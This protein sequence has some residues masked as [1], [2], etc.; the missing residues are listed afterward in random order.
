MFSQAVSTQRRGRWVEYLETRFGTFEEN[1][2]GVVNQLRTEIELEG[3]DA[4]IDHLRFC[5]AVP[6]QY[7]R[8]SSQEKLYS[9][10]TDVVV[11][12]ALFAIG[13][14]SVVVDEWADSADVQARGE[15]FSLVADAKAFRLSRTAK[16]QKDFKIQALDGWRRNLDYAVL[17][18]PIY[19]LPTR[20]SQIYQQA[21]ARN[22]CIISY[23]HLSTLIAFSV[24]QDKKQAELGFHNILQ[25]ISTL[26][27]S[28][29][30]VD[31]WTG[32][33]KSL[34]GVVKVI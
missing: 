21:I 10:Y 13:L 5:G 4:L 22:V 32:I 34:G 11:S 29:I 6:E 23:S 9:K 28:K 33:N 20:N 19:Q 15:D 24:R 8:D 27:P 2:G 16:N 14:K 7:S 3:V 30:A 18:C 31:Y 1:S 25:T 17:A 12:E 26:N